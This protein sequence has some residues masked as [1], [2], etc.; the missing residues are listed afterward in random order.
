MHFL[1]IVRKHY[2]DSSGYKV[3]W[4][5]NLLLTQE[6]EE[7]WLWVHSEIVYTSLACTHTPCPQSKHSLHDSISY[8]LLSFQMTNKYIPILS[9]NHTFLSRKYKVNLETP[10]LH[11]H[12]SFFFHIYISFIS[13]TMIKTSKYNHIYYQL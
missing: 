6:E 13:V 8:F 2:M 4:Q 3:A 1:L 7:S 5:S 12:V 10:K 9:L 11:N